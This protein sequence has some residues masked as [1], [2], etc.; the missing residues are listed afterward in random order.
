MRLAGFVVTLTPS[1]DL[2]TQWPSQTVLSD[3]KGHI[4]GYVTNQLK[5]METRNQTKLVGTY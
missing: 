5:T 3:A 4:V 1:R 2:A